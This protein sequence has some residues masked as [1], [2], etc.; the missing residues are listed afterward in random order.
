MSKILIIGGGIIGCALAREVALRGAEVTLL[1]A[2]AALAQEASGAAVGT[3]SYS[4]SSGM[5]EAWHLLAAP[6]LAAHR[7]LSEAL[8]NEVADAPI[9]H[10]TGRLSVVTNNKAEKYTRK[11]VKEDLA[12]GDMSEWLDKQAI[13]ER[14]PALGSRVQGGSFKAGHG[15]VNAPQL[16]Q[17][18]AKAAQQQGATFVLNSPVERLIW[19]NERVIGV[20]TAS[21]AWYADHIVVA[22]GAW[23]GQLDPGL[24]LPIEPVR[25]QALHLD[26]TGTSAPQPLI[27]HLVSGSSIYIIPEQNGVTIGSTHENVGFTPGI[28]AGGIAKLLSNAITLLPALIHADWARA[29]LWSGL[30]PA[31]PDKTPI[32]GP[33]PRHPGL[34]WATGHFRS[35]ILLAPTTATLLADAILA[36]A[37]ID[38]RFSVM[39]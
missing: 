6:S 10:W 9:W 12:R 3:L 35:G 38:P 33:D 36:G 19:A 2:G 26:L 5:P 17:A 7:A 18:L 21:Q 37:E 23:S 4:P 30:R 28:T 29:R 13:H 22:A 20:E 8:A 32:L 14:E 39:R 15:W 34:T 24:R 27:Q 1:E 25:G 16:T 11:R 31:T